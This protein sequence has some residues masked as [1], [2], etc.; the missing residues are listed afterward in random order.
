MK[1]WFAMSLLW[2]ENDNKG[3]KKGLQLSMA[4]VLTTGDNYWSRKTHNCYSIVGI[5]TK[6][7]KECVK[8]KNK[9]GNTT[10][11]V[12][13]SSRNQGSYKTHC[14]STRVWESRKVENQ[15]FIDTE[16]WENIAILAIGCINLGG[17]IH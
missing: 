8:K 3:N 9:Q 14:I 5:S 16:F 4:V 1:N 11:P 10:K 13:S 2:T 6:L 17:R 15:F 12:D 7:I